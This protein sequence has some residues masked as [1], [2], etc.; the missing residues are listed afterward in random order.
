MRFF[1]LC[2]ERG[3]DVIK[4][5]VLA[6]LMLLE[7]NVISIFLLTT[8]FTA[9]AHAAILYKNTSFTPVQVSNGIDWIY[10]PLVQTIIDSPAQQITIRAIVLH[11][12]PDTAEQIAITPCIYSDNGYG[13]YRCGNSGTATFTHTFTNDEVNVEGDYVYNGTF[14]VPAGKRFGIEI[15]SRNENTKIYGSVSNTYD[16]D[17]SSHDNSCV[18]DNTHAGQN[19]AI[20]DGACQTSYAGIQDFYFIIC[21]TVQCGKSDP[22]ITTVS[23]TSGPAGTLVTITGSSFRD[24]QHTSTVTFDST[25]AAVSSWSD[26][27]IQVRVP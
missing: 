8:I 5:L 25:S 11:E 2:L 21:D 3:K 15:G 7:V 19:G 4:K 18:S 17:D 26:T 1:V 13:L 23:P 24:T 20:G 9:G 22:H 14:I 16:G 27:Q 12:K 10:N 6:F